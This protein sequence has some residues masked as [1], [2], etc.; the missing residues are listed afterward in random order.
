MINEYQLINLNQILICS[1]FEWAIWVTWGWFQITASLL[2]SLPRIDCK[3]LHMAMNPPQGWI[4]R[5]GDCQ[6]D[7]N[8]SFAMKRF[9]GAP[10]FLWR[11]ASP[12]WLSHLCHSLVTSWLH[13]W[14]C[15]CLQSILS[16]DG[17][18]RKDHV[19]CKGLSNSLYQP[20]C[21]TSTWVDKECTFCTNAK[22][23]CNS[24]K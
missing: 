4:L 3:E 16:R 15:T 20:L 22:Q 5:P 13:S 10:S 18:P 9:I 6:C 21:S 12:V 24:A 7:W 2:I 23:F 17:V 11:H 14:H 19:H 1:W 8:C